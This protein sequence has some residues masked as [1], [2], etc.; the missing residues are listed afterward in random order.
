MPGLV[1]VKT[2]RKILRCAIYTRVSTEEQSRKDFS[3][4][5]AQRINC[6]RFIRTESSWCALPRHYDDPGYS[7]KDLNRPAAQQLLQDIKSGKVDVVVVY[8]MDRLI[9]NLMQQ[10]ALS[11]MFN[12]YGVLLYAEGKEVELKSPNG[13]LTTAISGAVAQSERMVTAQRTRDKV[14]EARKLGMWTGGHVPLGYDLTDKKNLVVNTKEAVQVRAMFETYLKVQSLDR[15]MPIV[16]AKFRTKTWTS[17]SG[18]KIGGRSFAKTSYLYV[19]RSPLYIGKIAAGDELVQGKHKAIVS[20]KLYNSVQR[21]LKRNYAIRKSVNCNKYHFLL[22]GLIRC[23]HCGSVMS[24]SHSF[25][26]GKGKYLYYKCTAVMHRGKT[27]CPVKSVKAEYIERIILNR[28]RFLGK[29]P[30]VIQGVIAKSQEQTAVHLPEIKSALRNLAIEKRKNQE[31]EAQLLKAMKASGSETSPLVTR[32]LERLESLQKDLETQTT[33]K[34]SE[35]E[36]AK[37]QAVNPQ[38]VLRALRKFTAVFPSLPPLERDRLIHALVYRIIYDGRK[39]KISLRLYPLFEGQRAPADS[40]NTSVYAVCSDW[41]LDLD[42][43]QEPFD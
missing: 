13:F 43:N 24:S 38:E 15:A 6:E 30:E 12:K 17:K 37:G 26:R 3:S 41:L 22:R 14:R 29:T 36:R 11:E 32:E 40:V 19:L 4:L 20:E 31:D 8:K 33:L 16:N 25:G 7:G 5:D 23:A 28:I 35:L 18:K 21:L 1:T 34:E 2:S 27:A 42:S 39:N 10:L 9:R